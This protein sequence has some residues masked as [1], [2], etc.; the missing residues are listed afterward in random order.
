M[1]KHNLDFLRKQH[2][3]EEL[4]NNIKLFRVYDWALISYYQ[5]LSE[6][7]IEKYSN[8]LDWQSISMCQNLSEEFIRKHINKICTHHLMINKNI[9][10]EIK[11]E[12]KTLKEII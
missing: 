7:F 9:S 11:K 3:E 10:E 1:N 5:S 12:I 2:S 8:K 4:K 6:I